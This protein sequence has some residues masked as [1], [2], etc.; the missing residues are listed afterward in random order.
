MM[1]TVAMR[2]ETVNEARRSILAE[3]RDQANLAD[4]ADDAKFQD[5]LSESQRVLELS[6][7]EVA[8]ILM[9]SRPTINRWS[10]GKN[11]PH[12]RVRKAVFTWIADTA[13]RRLRIVEK[14][15]AVRV[16]AG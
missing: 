6:D 2:L 7:R 4:L 5:L 16:A 9:V 14:G 3:L 1:S 8:D 12:R 11:L 10:N 13:S 15:R